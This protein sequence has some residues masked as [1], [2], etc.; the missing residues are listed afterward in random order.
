MG[1]AQVTVDDA[2]RGA[3]GD[4]EMT[5][6]SVLIDEEPP[7]RF[8]G[9]LPSPL[10]IAERAVDKRGQ[11]LVILPGFGV[12]ARQINVDRLLWGHSQRYR[13]I[14]THDS[15][16]YRTSHDYLLWQYA[17]LLGGLEDGPVNIL[18]IS[19]GGSTAVQLLFYLQQTDR[20]ALGRVRKLFTLV[21]A[22]TEDDLTTKGRLA[23]RLMRELTALPATSV[24]ARR[25]LRGTLLRGV[26]R[27]LLPRVRSSCLEADSSEE[28]IW[29]FYHAADTYNT[30]ARA[31][32][33]GGLDL[34]IVSLGTEQDIVAVNTEAHR[35]SRRGRHVL[36]QGEHHPDFYAAAKET[37]DRILVSELG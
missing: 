32:P 7:A 13:R 24:A 9:L 37:F 21:S 34:E 10:C 4:D 26:A 1:P 17:R 19:L 14:I 30:K 31:L 3:A 25:T 16:S 35:Y 12:S 6:R 28:L 29:T 18:G 27:A 36:V 5:Y 33:P 15:V 23:I 2:P 22:I 20:A 11:T 8:R